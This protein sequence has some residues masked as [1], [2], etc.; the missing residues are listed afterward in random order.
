M[1]DQ[2]VERQSGKGVGIGDLTGVRFTE[3][4]SGLNEAIL[5][6][7]DGSAEMDFYKVGLFH[8]GSLRW[9]IIDAGTKIK[10]DPTPPGVQPN[11][12]P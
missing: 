11:N 1:D 5:L 7:P 4:P 2:S 12:L 9:E 10:F 3:N 6:K 8:Q